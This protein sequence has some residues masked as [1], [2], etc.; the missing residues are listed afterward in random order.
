MRKNL[1]RVGVLAAA[2]TMATG[3][4]AF[5]AGWKQDT[6]G[7]YYEYDDGSWQGCGWAVVPL[8]ALNEVELGAREGILL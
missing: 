6:N 7:W 8:L 4:T 3:I 2:M 1:V 5:A